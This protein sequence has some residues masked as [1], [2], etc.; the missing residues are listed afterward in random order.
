VFLATHRI[1]IAIRELLAFP[2][3]TRPKP[4]RLH[5]WWR[6]GVL[7]PVKLSLEG[8]HGN[9]ARSL[10]SY[11]IAFEFPPAMEVV[12]LISARLVSA[13]CDFIQH[14]GTASFV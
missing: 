10:T 6:I 3:V 2:A 12:E 13:V 1:A 7:F 9:C 14:A 5:S 11:F 8:V 4:T